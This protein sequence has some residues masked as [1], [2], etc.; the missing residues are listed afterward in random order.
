MGD[1]R[2][3][4]VC[5]TALSEV[6]SPDIYGR[7]LIIDQC[8]DCH[9]IW[10]DRG[11]LFRLNAKTL[12]TT[13]QHPT[14]K[15]SGTL[16]LFPNAAAAYTCPACRTGLVQLHE[17]TWP[18]QT[19]AWQCRGCLGLWLGED[20]V[21]SFMAFRQAK[22][23]TAREHLDEERNHASRLAAAEAQVRTEMAG[24][25]AKVVAPHLLYAILPAWVAVLLDLAASAWPLLRDRI[26]TE[27][28]SGGRK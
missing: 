26:D 10:F 8:P 22:I 18:K 24:D 12:E 4:P 9:G 15:A 2:C 20:D 25:V 3:C 19:H 21:H 17:A 28:G 1:P 5:L 27:T 6:Q 16:P 11:E 14:A 7:P 23:R 13:E